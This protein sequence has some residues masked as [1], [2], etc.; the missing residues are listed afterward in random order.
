MSLLPPH[1][2][3]SVIA[4]GTGKPPDLK[5][6][7]TGFLYGR[8][9]EG[10][11][12]ESFN[13]FLLTNKHVL[14]DASSVHIRFNAIGDSPSKDYEVS[15]VTAD[16]SKTWF[17][18][19]DPNIDVAALYINGKYLRE[20]ENRLLTFFESHSQVMKR[21][22]MKTRQTTEGDGIFV[23]GYPM[24]MVGQNSQHVIC[25]FGA[26]ARV[27]DFIQ[28]KAD[29]FL[30]DAN[31]FPGNSGGPVISCP[32]AFAIRG[33][34][35]TQTA[36]LIGM[37][38][39]YVTYQDV[40]VSSQTGRA[41]F[42]SEENSGLAEVESADSIFETVELAHLKMFANAMGAGEFAA[43]EPSTAPEVAAPEN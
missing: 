17:G 40:A 12:P 23:L 19:P 39:A 2:L 7:G 31:I 1:F 43:P 42:V 29:K 14:G 6:I 24:G 11:T 28:G 15:L 32:S 5:W 34:Q 20:N 25:R 37:V 41:I 22:D 27:R 26:L 35:Q 18:H 36:D 10:S 21:A 13:V 38:K 3:D 30:I 4:I 9:I 33:T 16:G 8:L